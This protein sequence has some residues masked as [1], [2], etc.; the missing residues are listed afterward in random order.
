MKK[1]SWIL[2]ERGVKFMEDVVIKIDNVYKKYRLGTIGGGTL[3]ADL[4]SWWARV[5]GKDDPNI[6]IGSRGYSKNATFMAL[7]GINL[8]VRKG[9]ILGIIGANGAGK[10]TMLKILSRV[11]APTKGN[12]YVKGRISSMLEVGTGF[13]LEMT[14]RENIYLNGA[15][16]G[17]SKT[18]VDRKINEIIEF[19]ECAQFIDTPVKRYS[20]GMYV[21]LAFAVS[22]HLDSEILVMDEVLAVG[23]IKFQQKC[24]G[25]MG[26]VANQ[27]KRTVLYVSHNMNTIRQ[28]CN[29]CVVLDKGKIIY[30]GDVEDAI[31]F[32]VGE[33]GKMSLVNNLDCKERSRGFIPRLRA[34]ELKILDKEDM[35]FKQQEK[36]KLI[37]NWKPFDDIDD[38][39]VRIVIKYCDTSPVGVST[40]I[41]PVHAKR[42][43]VCE[44]KLIFD[45]STLASGKYYVDLYFYRIDGFGGIDNYDA[46][47][48][49]FSFEVVNDGLNC[50][51]L[52]WYHNAWGH[53]VFS[54]IEILN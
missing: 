41:K 14:G 47:G 16:L 17:M 33:L 30:D 42:G 39:Y 35:L 53:N 40:T 43:E 26:D 5:R 49:A 37:I 20:S 4:Q 51:K 12:I 10:S 3:T 24:L 38:V 2:F 19:S 9:D 18:E 8:E 21:K 28:L 23:D 31:Q 25:K 45:I 32:Y 29:R 46:I 1:H 44:T 6:K 52:T 15:I 36:I 34:L 11:T 7:S 50:N 13:N 48:E 27:E 22:A 54:P